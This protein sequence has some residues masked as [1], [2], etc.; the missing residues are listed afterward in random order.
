MASLRPRRRAPSPGRAPWPFWWA[1]IGVGL[2][3]VVL[4]ARGGVVPPAR[5]VVAA[6]P[7]AAATPI[8][9]LVPIRTF[10]PE[11]TPEQPAA[12]IGPSVTPSATI[13]PMP[14][15]VN[16]PRSSRYNP[17]ALVPDQELARQV[18]E[19]LRGVTAR[20]GV[21]I[22]DLQTGRGVLIAPETE[23]PAA[24]VF[25]VEVMYEVFKQ[26][27]LGV[28]AFDE[29]LVLTQRHVDFDL[30]TLDRGAGSPIQLDDALERMITISDNSAAVLLT[31]RVGALNINR[32]M[33]GLGLEHSRVLADDLVTSAYDMMLF[34]EM[35]ARGQGV[36]PEASREML[37]LLGRQRINDRIPRLLPPG[38]IAAHK[39]GNLPGVVNDV[40]LVSSPET[41]FAIAVLM[42]DTPTEGLAA[43]AIAEITA[44][45]YRYFRSTQP[46]PTLTP[47][48]T[49]T[50]TPTLEPTA[51]PPT[52][53][54][55]TAATAATSGATP[56][57]G[58]VTVTP[59]IV[60]AG[61]SPTVTRSP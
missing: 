55:P 54:P 37:Q 22:K 9:Q 50:E 47:A 19:I 44:A 57:R 35:L 49:A 14:T 43:N 24:S 16:V 21:A 61:P 45:A 10:G 8:P 30:G 32:D 60:T 2:A 25:K 15:P 51:G 42:A 5:P 23:F 3:G 13:P 36:S 46:T 11:P 20:V 53:A 33:A 48:V 6:Q 4:V 1:I 41:T 26:R 17:T 52:A 28:L 34:M 27:E 7:T 12:T 18:L 31:D 56:T 39:T 38:T 40:G 29:M 59:R 58:T